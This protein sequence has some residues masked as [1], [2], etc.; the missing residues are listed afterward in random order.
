M[1]AVN[2][3]PCAEKVRA[4]VACF[5]AAAS[6]KEELFVLLEV[7]AHPGSERNVQPRRRL[8]ARRVY[9]GEHKSLE[10]RFTVVVGHDL[11]TD[12]ALP[13]A[14]FTIHNGDVDVTVTAAPFGGSST[15]FQGV[16]DL[17]TLDIEKTR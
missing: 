5:R 7:G 3:S 13:L 16:Y 9:A 10:G 15:P 14:A 12:P 2:S 6:Q 1:S 11:A 4:A 17:R 8:V